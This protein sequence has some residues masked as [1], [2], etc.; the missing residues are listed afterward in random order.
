[1][2]EESSPAVMSS[3]AGRCPSKHHRRPAEPAPIGNR[4]FTLLAYFTSRNSRSYI[5]VCEAVAFRANVISYRD[6]ALHIIISG[7][8]GP[9]VVY[10]V[11]MVA[12]LA[13]MSPA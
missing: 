6:Q 3:P 4:K 9:G 7:A 5:N 11:A 2:V 12:V 1:M 10:V 8:A 13:A